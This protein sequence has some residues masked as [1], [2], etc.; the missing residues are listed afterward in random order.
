MGG[1]SMFRIGNEEIEAVKRVIESGELFRI[2]NGNREV[3]H[4]E[5]ELAAKIGTRYSLCVSGGT[6]AL[7][8]ALVG[9]EIGPGDEVLVPGYTFMAINFYRQVIGYLSRCYDEVEIPQSRV[10]LYIGKVISHLEQDF[11]KNISLEELASLAH[12]SKTHF[13]RMFKQ[14]TGWTPVA[15]L[16]RLRIRKARHLLW[17]TKLPITEISYKVGFSDSNYFTRQFRKITG[18]S[19]S[20]WRNLTHPGTNT[21]HL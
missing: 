9:L 5:E 20:Q 6:G 14:A 13:M 11:D 10:F 1:R 19:P 15:Y 12:M 16:I 3:D 8:A 7:I 21:K 2:N 4:F 18:Y 17:K